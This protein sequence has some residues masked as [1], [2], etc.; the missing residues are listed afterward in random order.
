M[1]TALLMTEQEY[2]ATLADENP[3]WEYFDGRVRQKRAMTKRNHVT[4]ANNGHRWFERY[5]RRMGGFFGQTPTTNVGTAGVREYLVPDL[6][7]WAPG[8]PVGDSA[9]FPPTLAI[10]IVSDDQSVPALR[11]KCRQYLARGVDVCWLIDPKKRTVETFEG[12]TESRLMTEG[13]TL[14]SAFLPGFTEPV[15]DLFEGV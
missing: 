15:S 7:Y 12:D 6:A 9:F 8:K 10:E 13:D 2:L 5:A 14:V 11:D 4:V 1:A 3:P